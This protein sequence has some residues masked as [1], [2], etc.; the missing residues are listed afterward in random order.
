MEFMSWFVVREG[1]CVPKDGSC[2]WTI[3]FW[4]RG[5]VQWLNLKLSL[6]RKWQLTFLSLLMFL[7]KR[8]VLT[9]Y[10]RC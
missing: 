2:D 4:G 8:T 10:C 3:M 5:L 7:A 6:C 9:F 1:H